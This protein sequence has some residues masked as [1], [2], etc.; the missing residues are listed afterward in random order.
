MTEFLEIDGSRFE[1]GGQILRLALALSIIRSTPVTVYNIRAGR[2]NPGLAPSHLSSIKLLADISNAKV[3]GDRKSSPSITFVPGPVTGGSFS[4]DCNTAGS[5]T[6]IVQ[7]VVPVLMRTASEV[8]ITGG[9]D[10]PFSPPTHYMQHVLQPFLSRIGVA[11]DYEVLDYGMY[12]KGGGRSRV[13]TRPS[14]PCGL[15]LLQNSYLERGCEIMYSFNYSPGNAGDKFS[16]R[17]DCIRKEVVESLGIEQERIEMKKVRSRDKSVVVSAWCSTE[18]VPIHG[19]AIESFKGGECG[20]G[21]MCREVNQQVRNLDCVDQYLQD[22]IIV[23]L[24]LAS[25]P[26]RIRLTMLTPHTL[27]VIELI[28]IFK[29]ADV[30]YQDSIL[31]ISPIV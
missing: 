26:S 4:I 11:F 19:H 5:I 8:L 10:V 6:L 27:A 31:S 15:E 21:D 28:G 24:A 25:S 18:W 22:Q 1:G 23:F 16:A 14:T 9:T 30:V 13:R 29:V 7:A 17:L 12:P 2:P 20:V 3:Q